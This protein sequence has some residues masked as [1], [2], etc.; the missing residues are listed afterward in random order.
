MQLLLPHPALL[1]CST[2]LEVSAEPLGIEVDAV[3]LSAAV[4]L[5][6]VNGE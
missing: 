4:L 1:D 5:P 2:Y 6:A 3:Y